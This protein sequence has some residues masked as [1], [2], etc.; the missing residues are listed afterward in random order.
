MTDT[1][2]HPAIL[3]S[4][5]ER[6]EQ[7][8]CSVGELVIRLLSQ[9]ASPEYQQ[10]EARLRSLIDSQTVLFVR[11]NMAGKITF[12]SPSWKKRFP[13]LSKHPVGSDSLDSIWHEDHDEARQAVVE[14]LQNPDEPV[15]VSLRKPNEDGTFFRTL[16]EFLAIR[17][18]DG[19]VTE[20]QCVG[21]DTTER[22]KAEE[23]ELEAELLKASLKKEREF[24]GLIQRTVSTL[25]HDF[26]T[27]LAVISIKKELLDRYFDQLDEV[28]RHEKLESIGNQLRIITN[29]LDE[30]SM[31]VKSGLN[32]RVFQPTHIQI[33]TLCR[34]TIGEILGVSH[35]PPHIILHNPSRIQTFF[36]DEVLVSRILLN[37]LSNAVKF[38]Q[39]EDEVILELVRHGE[40]LI[41]KV[42]DHGMGI[43]EDGMQH[44]FEPFYRAENVGQIR[45]TGLG[46]NIVKDCIER[47][48]GQISVQSRL[49]EGATFTVVLPGKF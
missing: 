48:S 3:Q 46:L 40:G 32:H 44:L 10:N 7:T 22:E 47:H 29:M 24:N 43:P 34:L 28:N 20:I 35:H 15:Q 6:A 39:Q 12:V 9:D 13:W 31:T 5:K 42:I 36:G 1:L 26:R 11:T 27:S 45:G 18:A 33:D 38:S 19:Q 17:G 4:L 25:S 41:I 14:C 21:F 8:H 23:A 49:N 16:W 37:L 30:L 2:L